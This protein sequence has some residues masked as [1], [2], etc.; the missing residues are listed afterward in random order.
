MSRL[1]SAEDFVS[2]SINAPE[3]KTTSDTHTSIHVNDMDPSYI[4]VYDA[5]G[6]RTIVDVRSYTSTASSHCPQ[7][8]IDAVSAISSSSDYL[9]FAPSPRHHLV[10]CHKDHIETLLASKK[11]N[12]RTPEEQS[13]ARAE[14]YAQMM[15]AGLEDGEDEEEGET[16]QQ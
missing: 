7:S 6:N 12:P 1:P 14:L 15:N 9:L 16:N 3:E 10:I 11:L 5:S 13:A 2:F 8:S 4:E